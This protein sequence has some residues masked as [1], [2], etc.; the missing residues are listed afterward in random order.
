MGHSIWQQCLGRLADEISDEQFDTYIKPLQ[1]S[2]DDGSVSMYAPNIYVEEQI[3]SVYLHRIQDLLSE[4]SGLDEA[5]DV[6][7]TVGGREPG[8]PLAAGAAGSGSSGNKT[9]NLNSEFNFDTFVEG[10]SN[11]LAK[12]AAL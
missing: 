9:H 11:E 8:Q 10:K 3:R 6:V 5:L 2:V 7:L 4:L 1:V 12:A